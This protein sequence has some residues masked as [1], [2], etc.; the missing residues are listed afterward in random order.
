LRAVLDLTREKTIG[1]DISVHA[2]PENDQTSTA[3]PRGG[4]RAGTGDL[5]IDQMIE[6][7]LP[8]QPQVTGEPMTGYRH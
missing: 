3:S 2:R 6:K 5:R 1:K 4:S 8:V 7:E